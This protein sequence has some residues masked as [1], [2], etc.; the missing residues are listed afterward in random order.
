MMISIGYRALP[1]LVLGNTVAW[2][3]AIG[4]GII[5]VKGATRALRSLNLSKR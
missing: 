2:V 5:A 1:P 3:L 4:S